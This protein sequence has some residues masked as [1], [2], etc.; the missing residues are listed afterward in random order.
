MNTP[1]LEYRAGLELRAVAG[2][3]LVGIAAPYGVTADLGSFRE[4]FAPG[5]WAATLAAPEAVVALHDHDPTRLLGRVKAGTL[6]IADDARGL[7]F[8]LLLPNTQAGNDVLELAQRGDIGGVS[9]GMKVLDQHWPTPDRREIRA[10]SLVELSIVSSWPAYPDTS[11]ALRSRA[12]IAPPILSPA[13]R[14]RLLDML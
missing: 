8:T 2:R 11:V 10:A 13:A 3:K 12:D 6:T 4:T 5:C 14:R 7:A 9:V 1:A